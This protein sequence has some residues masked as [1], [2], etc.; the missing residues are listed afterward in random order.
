M[1]PDMCLRLGSWDLA[2]KQMLVLPPVSAAV[3]GVSMPIDYAVD[4][5]DIMILCTLLSQAPWT[6]KHRTVS[7]LM[8]FLVN[9]YGPELRF[10]FAGI[11]GPC[12]VLG[13]MVDYCNA[14]P[15]RRTWGPC[16]PCDT[17]PQTPAANLRHVIVSTVC[18]SADVC[19]SR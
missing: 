14:S 12:S 16:S 18:G 7:I 19:F 10:S 3:R 1:L 15:W 17:A 4:K 11:W 2:N 9:V 8:L 13:M 5:D 6:S